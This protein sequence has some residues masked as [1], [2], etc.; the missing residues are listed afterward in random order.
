MNSDPSGPGKVLSGIRVLDFGRFIAAPL[1]GAI[2]ADMG[3]DVI[4]V[5]KREGGEDRWVQPVAAGGEGATFLQCNRNKR[6]LT[7]DT[8]SE[9]G[10]ELMRQLVRGADVVLA[11]MPD[12]AMAANGL[13]YASLSSVKP[14]IILGRATAF[15]SGGPYADRVG[16]DGIG[17]AMSGGTYRSGPPETP[18][19]S[20]VPY[21]DFGT[22][23]AMATGVM[24][25]LFHRNATGL[26]Q[27]VEASLLPVALTMANGMLIEQ[28]LLKLDRGRIGNRGAAVAPCDIFRLGDKW[29]L[30]QTS[31]NPMF[32]RWCRMV[33]KPEWTSDPR[34][35]SDDLRSQQSDMLNG[36]MQEWCDGKAYDQAMAE[37]DAARI[38]AG[39]VYTPQEAVDDENVSA[40]RQLVPM[41][42]PGLARPA[43]ISATP[44]RMSLT[45]GEI[46]S[47]APV[48]GEHN[49]AILGE[50][51]IG[52]D[53]IAILVADGI[54]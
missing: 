7:L 10:Q 48:L 30:V 47:R 45:P 19:R 24:M 22:G 29:I 38:P 26:G 51:G 52:P 50:L 32:R 33:G 9:R 36:A 54:I 46:V 21:V 31:G 18:Y 53:D 34:F 20:A 17:Q 4:R 43:P 40:L 5:E 27:E 12:A 15:G 28:E 25:A 14:D 44:F 8:T 2:L 16:F 42:Y 11:N 23:L 41:D 37:L 39:P 13:D 3:A 35:A 6:S 49:A 1:C